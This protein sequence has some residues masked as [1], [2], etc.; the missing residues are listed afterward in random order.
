MSTDS[1]SAAEATYI[2]RLGQA[3][4]VMEGLSESE[5]ANFTLSAW[6]E[7]RVSGIAGCIAGHCGLDPWFQA[8]GLVTTVAEAGDGIGSV[9]ILPGIFFGT[10]KPFYLEHYES[11]LQQRPIGDRYVKPE[12]AIV[13][14]KEAINEFCIFKVAAGEEPAA[15]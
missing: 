10:G 12:D 8:Q 13:A 11:V 14:L 6:A 5:R 3:V 9:N 2:E 15:V 1:T 7:R 4:R